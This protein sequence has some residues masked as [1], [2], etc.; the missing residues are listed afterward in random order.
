[1]I[2]PDFDQ[3]SGDVLL[4][5][6]SS[7]TTYEL[8]ADVMPHLV[9]DYRVIG[10]NYRSIRQEDCGPFTIDD[11]AH[12]TFELM[13]GLGISEWTIVGSSMGGFV[14]LKSA[15]FRPHSIS[16]LVL[17]GTSATRTDEQSA[18]VLEAIKQLEGQDRVGHAWAEWAMRVCLADSFADGNPWVVAEWTERICQMSAAN[19][20]QEF[21][22]SAARD[23]L[24]PRLEEIG[25]PTLVI[26]GSEDRAFTVEETKMWSSLIPECEVHILEGV[27]HFVSVESPVETERILRSFLGAK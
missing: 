20:T 15:L 24:V 23:D 7:N 5:L 18:L 16:R 9:S 8:F 1:M 10:H 26:H 2:E 6:N 27:G 25:C 13:D 14:G 4:F 19:I 11:L 22:A 12:D 21:A 17:I 3:G